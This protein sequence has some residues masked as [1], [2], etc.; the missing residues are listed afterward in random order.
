MAKHR[1]LFV[2]LSSVPHL[3]RTRT[4]NRQRTQQITRLAKRIRNNIQKELSIK[5]A[6]ENDEEQ[7]Q[8]PTN[9]K[10][11][12]KEYTLFYGVNAHKKELK[13]HVNIMEKDCTIEQEKKKQ[14]A[15]QT[16][17]FTRASST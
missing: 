9:N 3:W 2:A 14:R 12:L 8:R 7:Q 5:R 4:S 1:Q 15:E 10:R 17:F 11:W 16:N 6:N 13:Q